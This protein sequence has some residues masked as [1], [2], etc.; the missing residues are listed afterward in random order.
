MN[1]PLVDLKI[2]YNTI[3]HEIDQ[4]ISNVIEQTAFI[5]GKYCETFEREF[6]EFCDGEYC[7][8]VANGT[9]ALFITLKAL[10]IG[11]GDEVITVANTFIA[12]AEAIVATGANAVFVDN[13]AEDFTIDAIRITEK[14][15][16]KTKAIIPVHLYGQSADMQEIKALAEKYHLF[17]IEDAAQAHGAK[18]NGQTVGTLG[19]AACF[20]FYPGKNLGAYGDG[21]AIVTNNKELAETCRMLADHGRL[22]KYTHKMAGYNM[23]LDGLQAAILSV[24]LKHLS[25]WNQR[26]REI[27][28]YYNQHISIE[29]VILPKVAQFNEHVYH[30]YVVQV[31]RRDELIQ[32]FKENGIGAGIHYPIPLPHQPAFDYLGHKPGDFPVSEKLALSI[33][34]LPMFP[35]LTTE[36]LDYI[37][38]K[39]EEFYA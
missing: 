16:S 34:S 13:N 2:Q 27:A 30:L 25:Q 24:K 35:E 22:E 38:F 21:G 14:I 31:P 36:Q 26:R 12:T 32:F 4:A 6:A 23:R 1:I 3:R 9:D 17:I 37:I 33:L 29:N 28:N 11:E 19:D 39:L 15:S 8:G 20:S 7:I 10:G 5:G 18:H